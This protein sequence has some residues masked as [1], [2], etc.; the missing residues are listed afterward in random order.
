MDGFVEEAFASAFRGLAVAGI[1][2]DIGDQAGIENALAIVRGIKAAIKVERGPSEVQPDLF[3]YLLQG[4]EALRQ[5]DH[6]GLVDGSHG[7]RREDVAMIIDDGNNLLALLVFVSRVPNTIAPFLATVLVPSPWSTLVSS[8]CSAARWR[9]LARNACQ[10]DPSSA[11]L[12]KTLYT[13]V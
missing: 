8:C 5:Q 13:V 1:L 7:D 2:F 6:V 11:H 12:A 3:G 10:S 4:V 9:T